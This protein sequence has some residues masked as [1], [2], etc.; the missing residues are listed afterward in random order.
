MKRGILL[1][2]ALLLV[3]DLAEDSCLGKAQL[4]PP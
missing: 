2:L 1:I 4:I 3:L